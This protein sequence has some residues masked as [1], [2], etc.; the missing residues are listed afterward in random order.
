MSK[1]PE[2]YL[3]SIFQAHNTSDY[4]FAD[5]NGDPAIVFDLLKSG[6]K[7]TQAEPVTEAGARH[8][9]AAVGTLVLGLRCS[10]CPARHPMP[11]LRGLYAI[12]P[13]NRQSFA[14]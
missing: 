6:M 8:P 2:K 5:Y 12:A 7:G 4:D 13:A 9:L 14:M 3:K 1:I 10:S 11:K